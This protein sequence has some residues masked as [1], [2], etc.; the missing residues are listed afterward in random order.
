MKHDGMKVLTVAL[1]RFKLDLVSS[2]RQCDSM[3]AT[4][5][6]RSLLFRVFVRIGLCLSAGRAGNL[7]P[8]SSL[9]VGSPVARVGE[10]GYS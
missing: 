9:R 6:K 7:C 2:R 3:P 1:E 5:N 8:E 10:S 4:V